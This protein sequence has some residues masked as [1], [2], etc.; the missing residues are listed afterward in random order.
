MEIDPTQLRD[1]LSK[2][3]DVEHAHI[4]GSKTGSDSARRKEVEAVLTRV[5]DELSRKVRKSR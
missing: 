1:A 5:L 3:L 4:Y 2:V